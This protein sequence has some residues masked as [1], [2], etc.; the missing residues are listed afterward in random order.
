M[1]R[2]LALLCVCALLGTLG[3]SRH[4]RSTPHANIPTELAG[5][6]RLVSATVDGKAEDLGPDVVVLEFLPDG[7]WK[8]EVSRFGSVM[9]RQEGEYERGLAAGTVYMESTREEGTPGY[10][11]PSYASYKV[12][13]GTLTVTY[14]ED[15]HAGAAEAALRFE[16]IGEPAQAR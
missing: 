8:E 9:R 16:R 14:Y 4:G 5:K 12:E 10:E 13:D 11:V 3:C 2:C 1:R 7:K 15:E 6:W